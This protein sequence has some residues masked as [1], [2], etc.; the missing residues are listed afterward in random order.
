MISWVIFSRRFHNG[1]KWFKL[2]L[3]C[4]KY[5]PPS[6]STGRYLLRY[7]FLKDCFILWIPARQKT[8]I[9]FALY[10]CFYYYY[11][12][13][14]YHHYFYTSFHQLRSNQDKLLVFFLLIVMIPWASFKLKKCKGQNQVLKGQTWHPFYFRKNK[15]VGQMVQQSHI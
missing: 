3:H 9:N 15:K 2:C 10:K 13:Y 12:F 6:S 4:L 1:N 8:L 14:Y 11:R 5:Q 7:N